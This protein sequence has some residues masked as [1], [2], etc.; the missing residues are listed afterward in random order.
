VTNYQAYLIRLWREDEAAPWRG[1]LVS[2]RT[3][4]KQFFATA[5]Q[6]FA[7][8]ADQLENSTMTEQ[9]ETIEHEK[10]R[11]FRMA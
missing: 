8:L 4:D 11:N 1:E 5:D 6:L 10:S 2:P 9:Q 7:F 3:G